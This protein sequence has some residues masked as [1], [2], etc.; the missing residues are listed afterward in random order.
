MRRFALAAS[1]L[2][3]AACVHAQTTLPTAGQYFQPGGTTPTS[4]MGVEPLGYDSS[5]HLRCMVGETSTCQLQTNASGGGGGNAAAGLTGSAVPTSA[6]YE[7]FNS[8]GNLVGASSANPFPVTVISGGG[9]ASVGTVGGTTPTS[10]TLGG[11]AD[12]TTSAQFDQ[13][14]VDSSDGGLHIHVTNNPAFTFTGSDL[15]TLGADDGAILA[16]AQAPLAAQGSF[17]INI[18]SVGVLTITTGGATSFHLASSAASNNATLV[19]TGAHTLYDLEILTTSTSIADVRIYDS[20]GSPT[21][22]SA[23][24]VIRNYPV[25]ALSGTVG[26]LIVPIPPQGI[27]L[28]NGL[29]YCVTGAV[30]DNDNTNAPTGVSL[31]GGYK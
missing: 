12:S 30:A 21:C 28:T 10:A 6:S 13:F 22:S 8:G 4:A 23:T 17:G 18:G 14:V 9:G 3:F 15:N 7:G 11:G 25:Q 19:S 24:G 31:N 27:A 2:A 20:A 5:T 16:A 26:G 29:A 1:V